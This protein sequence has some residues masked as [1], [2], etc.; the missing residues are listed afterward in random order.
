MTFP[1]VLEISHVRYN[2]KRRTNDI[3][4]TCPVTSEISYRGVARLTLM[5]GHTFYHTAHLS[6]LLSNAFIHGCFKKC[7]VRVA[8]AKLV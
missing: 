1:V 3:S 8:I 4:C 5:V 6:L 7:K 2:S